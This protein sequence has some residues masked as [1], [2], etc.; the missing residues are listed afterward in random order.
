MTQFDKLPIEIQ[1]KMLERQVEQGNKRNPEVFRVLITTGAEKGGFSWSFTP[2]NY[3]FWY[4]ILIKGIIEYFS[5]IYSTPF[6][7]PKN[8]YVVVTKENQEALSKWYYSKEYLIPIDYAVEISSGEKEY[9]TKDKFANPDIFFPQDRR[10][11]ITFEQFKK[12]V[13]KQNDYP[14]I[15]EVS[16]F[17]D[18]PLQTRRVV[19]MKKNNV[20]LAWKSSETLEEAEKTHH[21][22]SWKYARD[23]K[24]ELV[25]L[26]FQDISDGKGIGIDPK[27]IRIKE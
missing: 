21:V 19:F 17:E 24:E 5:T 11:E 16:N 6:I 25:H 7:L 26:T 9:N 27:L 4:M 18:F 15:M 12:Y 10:K 1:E 23:I 2:E 20:F 13:M 22:T 8:W 14:K 3:Y